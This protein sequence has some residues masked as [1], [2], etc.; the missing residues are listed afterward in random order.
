MATRLTGRKFIVRYTVWCL[1]V[2]GHGP[3][4]CSSAYNCPCVGTDDDGEEIHDP[5]EFNHG[6]CD[7]GF[8][9]NDRNRCGEIEVEV[10]EEEYNAGT[11]QAFTGHSPDDDDIVQSLINAGLLKP[12]V[13]SKDVEI[14]GDSDEHLAVDDASD[15]RPLFQLEYESSVLIP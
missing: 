8:E 1:D 9:V 2:L 7:V 15:G 14:D 5:D 10:D 4:E 13:T 12:N 6:E 3:D 11:P